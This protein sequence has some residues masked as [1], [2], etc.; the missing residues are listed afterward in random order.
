VQQTSFTLTIA[1][2]EYVYA[3]EEHVYAGFPGYC[4]S[5]D[6]V[7]VPLPSVD[8]FVELLFLEIA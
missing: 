1:D 6:G 7:H 8:D 2:E 5:V 4:G 3:D